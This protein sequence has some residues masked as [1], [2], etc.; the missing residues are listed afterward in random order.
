MTLFYGAHKVLVNRLEMKVLLSPRDTQ[1]RARRARRG[2]QRVGAPPSG[3]GTTKWTVADRPWLAAGSRE[4]AFRAA[5]A[6]RDLPTT[7]AGRVG[8]L[9]SSH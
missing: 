6:R 2:D 1:R 9:T 3:A 5:G 7:W 8:S 4:I